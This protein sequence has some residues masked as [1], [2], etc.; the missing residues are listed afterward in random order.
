[1][2]GEQKKWAELRKKVHPQG[3]RL[4]FHNAPSAASS[5][6]IIQLMSNG[7]VMLL[8]STVTLLVMP[9]VFLLTR[10]DLGTESQMGK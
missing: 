9:L 10:D 7:V 1:M 4:T 6:G 5:P 2:S 8:P 3:L